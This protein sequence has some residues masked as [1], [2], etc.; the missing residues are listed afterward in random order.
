MPGAGARHYTTRQLNAHITEIK[1]VYYPWHPW[2]GRTVT[3]HA[4]L[5]K[6]NQTVCQCSL[7]P[8]E[9]AKA[10][11]VPHWMLERVVCAAM[12]LQAMPVASGA[13]LLQFGPSQNSGKIV[14]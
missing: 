2:H 12:P 10:S 9:P 14:R 6:R 1:E 3:I 4:V 11:E 8:N 13:A 5:V 7:E